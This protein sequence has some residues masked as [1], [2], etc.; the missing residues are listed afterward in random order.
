MSRRVKARQS[1]ESVSWE[2]MT[3]TDIEGE[4]ERVREG[5]K[6]AYREGEGETDRRTLVC[7]DRCWEGG[8]EQ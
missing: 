4:R 3:E 7:L 5:E 2:H 8:K 1:T 6:E